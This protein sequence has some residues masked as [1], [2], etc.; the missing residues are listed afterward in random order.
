MDLSRVT[1]V[2]LGGGGV[3]GVCY[4]GVLAAVNDTYAD[5]GGLEVWAAQLEVCAGTSIGAVFALLLA[6]ELP[7]SALDALLE[8]D[9]TVRRRLLPN[10]SVSAL[11]AFGV[12][13]GHGLRDMACG[14]LA[15]RCFAPN[16]T[17]GNLRRSTGGKLLVCTACNVV[18]M[19]AEY[20]DANTAPDMLVCDAVAASMR[21]PVVFAPF[22]DQARGLVL[23]DGGGADNFPM[24]R[25]VGADVDPEQVLGLRTRPEPPVPDLRD[26]DMV[27]GTHWLARAVMCPL[28]ALEAAQLERLDPRF[29]ERVVTVAS[30][31]VTGMEFYA[32]AP[33]YHALWFLGAR[34]MFDR[35]A[36]ERGQLLTAVAAA[37]AG[38]VAGS[39]WAGRTAALCRAMH[40]VRLRLP[41]LDS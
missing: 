22:V 33:I 5:R 9:G 8:R 30:G 3:R 40:R 16:I 21:V 11:H 24:S 18:D 25:V 10:P 19:R 32:G 38:T 2:A 23:T 26:A 39:W 41:A 13:D 34:T 14:L 17:L 20:L 31:T 37:V 15:R 29:Q 35:I 7:L 1:R 36:P 12:D 28:A 6:L 27:R 4:A